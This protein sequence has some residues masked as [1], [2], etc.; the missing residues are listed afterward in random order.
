MTHPCHIALTKT[1]CRG[2]GEVENFNFF[3]NAVAMLRRLQSC[4]VEMKISF[5][6]VDVAWMTHPCHIDLT[7]TCFRG[8]S[9]VEN[10]NFHDIVVVL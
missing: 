10:F 4:R 7:K 1:S 2:E 9:K 5:G 3:G 6:Q 8:V